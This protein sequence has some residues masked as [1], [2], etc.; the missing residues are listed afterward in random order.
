MTLT[1]TLNELSAMR[2]R[3]EIDA[4]EF[5]HATKLLLKE[6]KE[7]VP[8]TDT[9]IRQPIT[10]AP[11]PASKLAIWFW[12]IVLPSV[13]FLTMCSGSKEKGTVQVRDGTE[14]FSAWDGS[15]HYLVKKT[16]AKLRDPS[17]FDHVQTRFSKPD[18][19][20][21]ISVKMEYRAK[22]GFGGFVIENAYGEIDKHTCIVI[23]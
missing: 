17:S 8:N 7:N 12:V 11:K 16:K 13:T 21:R 19:M 14:C 3:G 1:D 22:N 6:A 20:G 2:D 15:S 23:G 18:D 9:K 5:A 10:E 4:Y